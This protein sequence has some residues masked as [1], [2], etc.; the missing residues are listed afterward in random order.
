MESLLDKF[1]EQWRR[2]QH[3]DKKKVTTGELSHLSCGMRLG[4]ARRVEKLIQS[5]D[6]SFQNEVTI[7]T[8]LQ[9]LFD[10]AFNRSG[11]PAL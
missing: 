5:A 6:R 8:V 2:V 7:M 1:A 3:N 4:I 10:L 11:K 9:M